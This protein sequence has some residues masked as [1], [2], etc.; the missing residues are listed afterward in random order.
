MQS[1]RDDHVGMDPWSPEQEIIKRVS[2]NDVTRYFWFQVSNLASETNLAKRMTT[3]SVETMYGYNSDRQSAQWHA[4]EVEKPYKDYISII[5]WSWYY[6]QLIFR[7]SIKISCDTLLR[8]CYLIMLH[9]IMTDLLRPLD[10]IQDDT[11]ITCTT[12]HLCH[13]TCTTLFLLLPLP[14]LSRDLGTYCNHYLTL[15]FSIL[16]PN[17]VILSHTFSCTCID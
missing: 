9:M 2:V 16:N 4:E 6:K 11:A 17:H 1:G 7:K 12:L 14:I 8:I 13:I 5:L 15:I 10:F 3:L